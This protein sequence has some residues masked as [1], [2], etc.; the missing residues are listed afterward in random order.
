MAVDAVALSALVPGSIIGTDADG[1]I[2]LWNAG[3]ARLYGWEDGQA[4]GRRADELL[5]SRHPFGMTAIDAELLA[6]GR[7]QG[8]VF[9]RTADG[10]DVCASIR[11]LVQPA[12][13]AALAVLEWGRDARKAGPGEI[14]AHRYTNVFHAMAAS[15]WEL[16]FT[17]VRKAIGELIAAGVEDVPARLRSD[18]EFIDHAIGLVQIVDVND[19][20]V[21]IFG[22]PSRDAI[23]AGPI[24]WAWPAQSR[25]VFAES[26]VAALQRRDRYS[27][28][29]VLRRMDGSRLDALFT[30]C[31]PD[32]HKGQGTVLVGVIDTTHQKRAFAELEA[33]ER[34]YRD[35]FRHIPI[36]LVQID[37]NPLLGRLETLRQ[38][39]VAD[40]AAYVEET[41]GFLDEVLRLPLIEDA[42]AEALRLFGAADAAELRGPIGWG[43][44]ERPETIRRSL[45]ARLRGAERYSEETKVTRRD[46]TAIDVLYTISFAQ[47]LTERGINVAGFVDISEQ[48]RAEARLR[49]MQADF[50][51]AA[52]VSV[53]GELTASIAHEVNQPLAAIRTCG[54]ASLRWLRRPWPDLAEVAALTNDIV[55]DAQRASEIIAR[56]RGM[57]LKRDPDPCPLSLNEV[58]GEALLIVR[59]EGLDRGV[60]VRAHLA[61]ALPPVM[62][63]RVQLQQVVVNL[64]MNAFQ[65]MAGADGADRVLT[66]TTRR[67]SAGVELVIE[68]T[69]SGIAPGHLDQ[70]FSGF[71][72]TRED[73]MGMGLPIC[74]TIVQA[75]A[76]QISATEGAAGARF[77]VSLPAI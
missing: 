57:A 37:M 59:H 5:A 16:D 1:R 6:A 13:D 31:W 40:L 51:H 36:A 58:V 38:Q 53:L 4:L 3:A 77:V 9:R 24:G 10:R 52:R 71:F 74:R 69:G 15:F 72:T 43:W 26:L 49:H 70:L 67:S 73:G 56:I 42:N 11:R 18:R 25:H 12:G 45:A 23:L 2:C 61:T 76:G 39:G 62:G 55:A 65:A 41:P 21:E 46:G 34:R 54:E 44:R 48:R 47:S 32:G 17:E 22:A 68:D 20:T 64:A 7:W 30:V 14:A 66:V 63:D 29:T 19:T 8:E 75:H 60:T 50:T 35:L 33:S 27:A 28:E